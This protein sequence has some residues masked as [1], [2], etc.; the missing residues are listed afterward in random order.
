MSFEAQKTPVYSE[1]ALLIYV[2]ALTIDLRDNNDKQL[3]GQRNAL[4]EETLTFLYEL[5]K[6]LCRRDKSKSS[7]I[8]DIPFYF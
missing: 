1:S 5:N 8:L 3:Y 6:L 4:K 2:V 7:D